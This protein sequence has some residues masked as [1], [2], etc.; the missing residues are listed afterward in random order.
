MARLPSLRANPHLA[1]LWKAFP[2]ASVPPLLDVHDALLRSESEVSVAERE[3]LAAYVSGL[4]GCEFCWG[5]HRRYAIA[6]GVPAETVDAVLEDLGSAPIDEKLKPL[7]AYAGKLTRTPTELSDEDAQA[8]Y[9]AGWSERA[10]YTAVMVCALF[11][12]MNRII[13]GCGVS[14]RFR[15]EPSEGELKKR[16]ESTY[17][18]FGASIGL[19]PRD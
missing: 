6:F 3:L 1:D 19:R 2:D 11:N 14:F 12:M 4:N 7:L 15:G 10:L 9:E 18:D 8:V 16:R 5:A 17:A 13:E